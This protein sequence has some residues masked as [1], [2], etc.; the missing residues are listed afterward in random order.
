MGHIASHQNQTADR[1][2]SHYFGSNDGLRSCSLQRSP[3]DQLWRTLERI[4][5]LDWCRGWSDEQ[6]MERLPWD[7]IPI[8]EFSQ[9][10]TIIHFL[11]IV[12]SI[13]FQIFML[14][15]RNISY[16]SVDADSKP[17]QKAQSGNDLNQGKIW[18]LHLHLSKINFFP[19]INPHIFECW[20]ILKN[21]FLV[22]SK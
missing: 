9:A 8:Y 14:L 11:F 22:L 4:N 7:N 15:D 21:I 10:L 17:A 1:L 12:P 20:R 13:A 2:T 19:F 6:H 5:W 3:V 18:S 16:T